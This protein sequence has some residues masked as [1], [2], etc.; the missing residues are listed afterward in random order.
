VA[1]AQEGENRLH[2]VEVA[3]LVAVLL[4][5]LLLLLGLLIRFL[6]NRRTTEVTLN[7]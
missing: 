6:L 5:L 2:R 3:G 7:R 4:V 1:P